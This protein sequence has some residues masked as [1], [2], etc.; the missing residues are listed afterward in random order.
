MAKSSGQGFLPLES[1][2]P[3]SPHGG[4]TPPVLGTGSKAVA[5]E[6]YQYGLVPL[7]LGRLDELGVVNPKAPLKNAWSSLVHPKHAQPGEEGY[8]LSAL[9]RDIWKVTPEFPLGDFPLG[10]VLGSGS[11]RLFGLDVETADAYHWLL[12]R[13]IDHEDVRGTD[14]AELIA[15]TWTARTPACGAHIIFKCNFPVPAKIKEGVPYSLVPDGQGKMRRKAI[16]E[17]LGQGN[18]IAVPL[19]LAVPDPALH[20]S[21]AGTRYWELAPCPA[22]PEPALITKDQL[23]F[24][25][26]TCGELNEVIKEPTV[27]K[28][29]HDAHQT[30]DSIFDRANR[31]TAFQE[32]AKERLLSSG[33]TVSRQR[34]DGVLLNRPG[35]TSGHGGT[36]GICRRP[37]DRVPQFYSF[38]SSSDMPQGQAMSPWDVIQFLDYGNDQSA[39]LSAMRTEYGSPGL[40]AVSSSPGK[41]PPGKPMATWWLRTE[42]LSEVKPTPVRWIVRAPDRQGLLPAGLCV[43]VG[44]PGAGKS[45]LVR[46]VVACVT[47]GVGDFKAEAGEA[48]FVCWEDDES[49]LVLPHLLAC[50]GDPRRVHLLRGI[51][52]SDGE[53]HDWK[54]ED[55]RLIKGFLQLHP[56]IRLIVVDVLSS[57]T[58]MSNSNSN[59]GEDIRGLLDPLSKLGREFGV[60]VLFLHHQNKKTDAR[61]AMRVAGSIQ[62][63]GCARLVWVLGVDPDAPDQRML[64]PVKSNIPGRSPGF[65]FAEQVVDPAEVIAHAA[66]LGVELPPDLEPVVYNRLVVIAD[67]SPISADELCAASKKATGETGDQACCDYIIKQLRSRRAIL[68]EELRSEANAI[69]WRGGTW[70]RGR[71]LAEK[72]GADWELRDKRYWTVYSDPPQHDPFAEK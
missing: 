55:L 59:S 7:R 32:R 42:R 1:P 62:I 20:A 22:I 64:A 6:Y 23:D 24:L 51:E 12:E 58:A 41:T 45:T 31:D 2:H 44:D 39:M 67:R 4:N 72:K 5:L 21:L 70:T 49:S 15:R 35:K 19:S 29:A 63:T 40:T 33:W 3:D 13:L 18:Q 61:S 69:G 16:V 9:E 56:D 25:W 60:S 66:S 68:S 50:G 52:S 57:L 71:A 11:G 30:E 38:T 48:L 36:W 54:P 47:T 37:S 8:S 46:Q 43:L 65:A 34:G 28:H 27:R 26:K 53:I 14:L 10:I 17:G